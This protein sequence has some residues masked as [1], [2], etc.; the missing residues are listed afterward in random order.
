[1]LFFLFNEDRTGA[2][3][4]GR[5]E[6]RKEDSRVGETTLRSS[7]HNPHRQVAAQSWSSVCVCTQNTSH[8]H[9]T[10]K[11]WRLRAGFWLAKGAV[12]WVWMFL[13]VRIA[14]GG[15]DPDA[16][17]H[18]VASSSSWSLSCVMGQARRSNSSCS[19]GAVQLVRNRE[20][21]PEEEGGS[22]REQWPL[23]TSR[24]KCRRPH[25]QRRS[26]SPGAVLIIQ[27]SGLKMFLT[28]IWCCKE[29]KSNA[30]ILSC[31][32]TRKIQGQIMFTFLEEGRM[33]WVY[34]QI[35]KRHIC[36]AQILI[37]IR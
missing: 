31:A 36:V 17:L 20:P 5:K 27:A 6:G 19:F 14:L 13:R 22:A 4:R 12:C 10:C 29:P 23:M 9:Y 21:L 11:I 26:N 18:L 35:G 25:Q 37:L 1:M 33:C 15:T 28:H 32:I 8:L 3:A 24:G 2:A 16:C 7:Q 34:K 30:M